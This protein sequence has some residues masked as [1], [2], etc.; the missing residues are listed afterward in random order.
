[1]S[2]LPWKSTPLLVS[3]SLLRRRCAF[4]LRLSSGLTACRF[5][6]SA[7]P[8]GTPVAVEVPVAVPVATPVAVEVPTQVGKA[9]VENSISTNRAAAF[10]TNTMQL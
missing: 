8:V 4:H 7:V 10:D 6:A 2:L 3:L 1:V 9:P 5:F